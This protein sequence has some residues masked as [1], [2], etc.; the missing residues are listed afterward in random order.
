[1]QRESSS[2]NIQAVPGDKL[3]T[4]AESAAKSAGRYDLVER[5]AKFGEE[6]V[7]FAAKIPVNPVSQR[8]I[9]QL[10]G[11]GT[12]IGA[13]YCEADDSESKR[14]FGTK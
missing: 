7:R 8:F 4:G 3:G 14:T 2:R 1:M 13:N 11:A 5:T 12:S 6:V 10:V 9:S